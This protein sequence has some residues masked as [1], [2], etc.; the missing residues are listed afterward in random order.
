MAHIREMSAMDQVDRFCDGLKSETRKE[1]MYLRCGTLSEAIAAAQAFERTHFHSSSEPRRVSRGGTPRSAS[2][3]PIPRDVSAVDTRSISKEQCRREGLGFYCK[4]T[5]HRI[6][7]CPR[8]TST[9]GGK[10]PGNEQ[11]RRM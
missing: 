3:A 4:R 1:V 2:D 7:Q 8:R 11:A 5:E 6:G 10:Y 9:Q